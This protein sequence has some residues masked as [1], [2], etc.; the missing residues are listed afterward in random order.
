MKQWH[1]W[2]PTVVSVLCSMFLGYQLFLA[3]QGVGVKARSYDKIAAENKAL[4]HALMGISAEN[5]WLAEQLKVPGFAGE[6]TGAILSRDASG[7]I[8]VI[9]GSG[10]LILTQQ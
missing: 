2:L 8:H 9:R 3:Y 7:E 1:L 4:R 6:C 10:T 5:A